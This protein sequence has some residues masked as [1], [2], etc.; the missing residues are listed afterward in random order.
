[1]TS[2]AH[3]GGLGLWG[4]LSFSSVSICSMISE[5][6]GWS[7]SEEFGSIRDR[8][9]ALLCLFVLWITYVVGERRMSLFDCGMSSSW[10]SLSAGLW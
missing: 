9:D 10:L 2:G 3:L 1:V 7:V 4:A 5:C 8:E 6:V